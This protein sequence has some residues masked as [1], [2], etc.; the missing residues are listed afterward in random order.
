MDTEQDLLLQQEQPKGISSPGHSR[1]A[2]SLDPAVT[3]APGAKMSGY[4]SENGYLIEL[5][6]LDR[7]RIEQEIKERFKPGEIGQGMTSCTYSS[8]IL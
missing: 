4:Y 7:R 1:G 6:K 5:S 2:A 8:S 3:A